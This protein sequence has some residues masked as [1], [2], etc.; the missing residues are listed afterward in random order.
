MNEPV[1]LKS[2]IT[3][4]TWL[5]LKAHYEARL[6]ALRIQNDGRLD[7]DET[8]RLR[9]RIKEIKGFLALGDPHAP[10]EQDDA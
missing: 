5:R 3:S 8:A 2:D 9:G 1:L 7:A 6:A 10:P 4:E